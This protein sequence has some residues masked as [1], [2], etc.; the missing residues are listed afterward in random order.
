VTEAWLRGPVAGVDPLLMPAV[1]ALMHAREDV[2]ASAPSLTVEQVWAK[3]GASGSVGFHLRHIANSI[4]R[5]L[6]Y[7]RGSDLNEQQWA[8]LRAESTTGHETALA[9]VDALRHAVDRAI[10]VVRTTP[11]ATLHE[12]RTVGRQALPTTLFGILFHIGEHSARHAGQI[13]TLSKVVRG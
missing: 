6:T 9:L 3:P 12:K 10:S 5:M 11:V 2:E 4:D 13:V 1:H 7:A 8:A